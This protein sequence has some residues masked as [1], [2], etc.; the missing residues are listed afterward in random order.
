MAVAEGEV[1]AMKAVCSK[2]EQA[3][4]AG[5]GCP[6]C[7]P[8][9]AST[10]LGESVLAL[11]FAAYHGNKA[12][13]ERLRELGLW[14]DADKTCRE[15]LLLAMPEESDG[16][17]LSDHV[18]LAT[19]ELLKAPRPGVLRIYSGTRPTDADVASSNSALLAEHALSDAPSSAAS[20]SDADADEGGCA[21]FV[22]QL[23]AEME[24]AQEAISRQLGWFPGIEYDDS[25]DDTE[26]PFTS[27]QA[28]WAA[29]RMWI[30]SGFVSEAYARQLLLGALPLAL[31]EDD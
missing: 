8:Q 28:R 25:D 20:S 21:A 18:H 29:V 14:S 7:E 4:E 15:E 31:P 24:A 9:R 2:H 26:E 30:D 6:W 11:D 10:R 27:P 5:E 1:A 23:K 13:Q 22:E 17:S 16:R 3:Y 19:G 12:A